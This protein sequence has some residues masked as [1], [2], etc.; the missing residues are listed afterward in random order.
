MQNP[1]FVVGLHR[2]GSTVWH[3]LFAMHPSICRLA[4]PLI[5]GRLGQKDFRTFLRAHGQRLDVRAN[6]DTLVDLMFSR[7]ALPGLQ[8]A[9]WRF[10]NYQH[11]VD[12]PAFRHRMASRIFESDAAR[13][14]DAAM[15]IF[16]ILLDELSRAAGRPIPCVK[17]P[18]DVSRLDALFRA[19]PDSKVIH[20]TRDPR[21]MAMSK[22]NDP[23]GTGAIVERYPFLRTPIRRLFMLFAV[24]QYVRSS[25]HHS[26]YQRHRNYRLYRYEDLMT[27][28]EGTF[29]EVCDFVGLE[30]SPET[31]KLEQGQHRQ[32]RSSITGR[33][34][35]GI[36]A[37]GATRWR[38][39]MSPL[40]KRL[41]TLLT[42]GSMR[43][44][45]YH[46][47]THPIFDSKSRP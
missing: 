13:S 16:T 9:F 39:A 29:K 33:Q 36:D 23:G 27:N 28:P 21:A 10:E 34:T 26:K 42:R 18:V 41:V 31:L 20:I 3:N 25:V 43:R 14:K 4:D 46:P 30:F 19:F 17:F 35:S 12:D 7:R 11:I 22:T 8:S 6:V 37:S 47:L 32:Q 38:T 2:T 15:A 1:I 5:L 24:Y 44:F 40:E 45:D